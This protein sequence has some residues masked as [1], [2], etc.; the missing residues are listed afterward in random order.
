[1]TARFPALHPTSSPLLYSRPF[2][3]PLGSIQFHGAVMRILALTALSAVML[4]CGQQAGTGTTK[5]ASQ[6][7]SVSY[8]LGYKMGENLKQ[9]SVPVKPDIIYRGMQAGF[10]GQTP[11]MHDTV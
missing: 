6:D 3:N 4:G 11:V 8:I 1:M 10:T 7:D 5:L 9:Q 2:G